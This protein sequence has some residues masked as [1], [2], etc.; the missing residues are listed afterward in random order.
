MSSRP[1]EQYLNELERSSGDLSSQERTEWRE[2]VRQHLMEMARAHEA[3]GLSPEEAMTAALRDFGNARQIGS[4]AAECSGKGLLCG[5]TAVALFSVPMMAIMALMIG[6]AY[7]YVLTDSLFFLRCLQ[8]GGIT[9]FLT[10]P[11]LGGW[12]A[13]RKIRRNQSALP[14]L[15]ALTFAALGFSPVASVLLIPAFGSPFGGATPD[16]RLG[17]LWLPLIGL[18]VLA[19]RHHSLSKPTDCKAR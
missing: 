3:V 16:L 10:I 15:S 6:I 7:A 12:C 18:S 17:L 9:S 5:K 19:T 1:L 4:R 2:E 13:A 14:V 8:I 11:V